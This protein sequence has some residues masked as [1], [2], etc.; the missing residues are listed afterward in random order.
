MHN[1]RQQIE[2]RK[3]VRSNAGS[4]T[5][6][7]ALMLYFG[8]VHLAEPTGTDLFSWAAWIL[9]H[10]LRIGGITMAILAVW[11]LIGQPIVMA[12]DAFASII[13]GA[14]FM[15]TGLAMFIDGGG[16]F[17]PLLYAIFGWT[18]ISAGQNNRSTYSYIRSTL[19]KN[20]NENPLTPVYQSRTTTFSNHHHVTSNSATDLTQNIEPSDLE[21]ETM[22]DLPDNQSPID[23][24]PDGFL[25]SFANEEQPP[26]NET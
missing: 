5:I 1:D 19:N 12:V 25:A 4:T 15:L 17:Q 16:M 10:T 22:D 21:P 3:K 6:A 24:A 20:T 18:F 8:F 23:T 14:I 7:A 9:F 26:R 13:I 2:I 11:S